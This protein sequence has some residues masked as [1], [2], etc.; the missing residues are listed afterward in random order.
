MKKQPQWIFL[1]EKRLMGKMKIGGNMIRNGGFR[2]A[3]VRTFNFEFV[4]K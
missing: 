4:D 3:G 1:G 2:E